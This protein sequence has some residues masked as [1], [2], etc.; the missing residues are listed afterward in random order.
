MSC[1]NCVRHVD[2]ALREI[3]GVSSVEVNLPEGWA[4]VTHDGRA[5]GAALVSAVESAGYDAKLE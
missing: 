5:A 1:N 2:E 4:K 3:T